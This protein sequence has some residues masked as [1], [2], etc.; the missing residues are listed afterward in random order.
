MHM[1]NIFCS[2]VHPDYKLWKAKKKTLFVNDDNCMFNPEPVKAFL[3][4]RGVTE[5]KSKTDNSSK[6]ISESLQPI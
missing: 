3:K 6:R 1:E 2:Q 5:T 4:R